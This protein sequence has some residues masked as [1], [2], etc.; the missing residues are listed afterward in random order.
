MPISAW[1]KVSSENSLLPLIKRGYAPKNLS[2]VW[3][4]LQDQYTRRYGVTKEY[5]NYISMLK[6]FVLLNCGFIKTD[7]RYMLNEIYVLK[8]DIDEVEKQ[9]H[10]LE[11]KKMIPRMNKAGYK[12][13][14]KMSVVEFFDIL[15]EMNN[16]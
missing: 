15:N 5:E 8:A 2:D 1:E 11:L 3:F 9:T 10:K 12:V 7:E 13:S 14:Y 6:R 4:N 16:G